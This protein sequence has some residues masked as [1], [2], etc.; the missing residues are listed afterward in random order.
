MSKQ[1]V[2]KMD[3]DR[4]N[5]KELNKGE[6]KEQYQMI[7]KNKFVALENLKRIRKTSIG[8]GERMG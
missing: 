3:M 7:I 5:L 8:H 1:A 2:K 4:F 6:V